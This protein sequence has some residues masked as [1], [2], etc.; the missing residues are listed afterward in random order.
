[1]LDGAE[2][3]TV[4]ELKKNKRKQRSSA[5]LLVAGMLVP[6]LMSGAQVQTG[7]LKFVMKSMGVYTEQATI[8]VSGR[9]Y[10]K[11][12]AASA[13]NGIPLYSCQADAEN[14]SISKVR[15]LWHGIGD[16]SYVELANGATVTRVELDSDGVRK[17]ENQVASSCIELR[18][19]LYFDSDKSEL[20]K[21]Q[22]E[23]SEPILH[24]FFKIKNVGD[25]LLII[26]Y[27]DPTPRTVKGNLILS[28]DRA[29][30][31]YRRLKDGYLNDTD[32]VQIDARGDMEGIEACDTKLD[33]NR[34]RAC[35]ARNR[36]VELRLIGTN[37]AVAQV[38]AA[39][40]TVVCKPETK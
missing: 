26:G 36:R 17:S 5:I 23:L 19:G 22:L 37:A 38:G 32:Y 1:M 30:D 33:A 18:R 6:L 9:A 40:A 2:A 35:E 14:T 10:G 29:C 21:K 11:L 31:I 8:I 24:E 28:R 39:D 4:A 25:S 27:A 13:A 7:M 34:L 3:T 16:R 12:R 20:N 15:I